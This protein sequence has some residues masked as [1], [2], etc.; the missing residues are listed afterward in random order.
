MSIRYYAI[1]NNDQGTVL[2]G[3]NDLCDDVLSPLEAIQRKYG[4]EPPE[5]SSQEEFLLIL[6]GNL[7]EDM[8]DLM[9]RLK[10][11]PDRTVVKALWAMMQRTLWPTRSAP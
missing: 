10:E 6:V 3:R 5:E 1:T 2:G 4:L 9:A 11:D 8:A 7:Q